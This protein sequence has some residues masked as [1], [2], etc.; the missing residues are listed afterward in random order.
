MVNTKSITYQSIII[1]SSFLELSVVASATDISPTRK[2]I[3]GY[4]EPDIGIRKKE[5]CN[6][7][8]IKQ[9]DKEMI[10]ILYYIVHRTEMRPTRKSMT[11]WGSPGRFYCNGVRANPQC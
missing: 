3:R 7:S 4:F 1:K 8:P 9:I 6:I 5:K 2:V 10:S 11:M